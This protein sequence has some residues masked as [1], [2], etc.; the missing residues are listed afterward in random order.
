MHTNIEFT[1]FAYQVIKGS[2]TVSDSP[3]RSQI[4]IVS[5]IGVTPLIITRLNFEVPG[6]DVRGVK[7]WVCLLSFIN[8]FSLQEMS[9]EKVTKGHQKVFQDDWLDNSLSLG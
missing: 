4:P 6:L 2:P 3:P 7:P 1:L 9:K 8:L 5:K